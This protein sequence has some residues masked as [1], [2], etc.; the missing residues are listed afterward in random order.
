MWSLSSPLRLIEDGNAIAKL[1]RIS[2][3][4]LDVMRTLYEEE[5]NGCSSTFQL[6]T[7][8]GESTRR[9]PWESLPVGRY[10]CIPAQIRPLC[11][12]TVQNMTCASLSSQITQNPCV[13]R[14]RKDL[15]RALSNECVSLS[16]WISQ[17]RELCQLSDLLNN[18][19][20][21][22]HPQP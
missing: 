6:L 2:E 17:V 18:P 9:A 13:S 3:A 19:P 21:H 4:P 7:R 11:I 1:L 22:T 5:R 8:S 16:D 10:C 14:L 20:P 12:L 15:R